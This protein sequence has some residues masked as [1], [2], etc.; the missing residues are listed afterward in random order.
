MIIS[1]NK[2]KEICSLWHGGQ[3]S[4]LY[5]F[6]SSGVF[7]GPN[8]LKYLKEIQECLEPEFYLHPATLSKKNERELNSLKNFFEFKCREMGIVI[9]WQKHSIYGYL[10]PYA[11]VNLHNLELEPLHLAI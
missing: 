8:C 6:A 11:P 7:I 9:T 4:N 5:Q 2:A 3:W 10:I 1:K